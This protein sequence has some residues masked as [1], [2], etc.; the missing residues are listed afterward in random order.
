M[1]KD[2]SSRERPMEL[3]VYFWHVKRTYQLFIITFAS[4]PIGFHTFCES[5]V[6]YM[7]MCVYTQTR[8]S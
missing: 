6:D 4:L 3:D 2:Q 1:R 8:P 5:A 7:F